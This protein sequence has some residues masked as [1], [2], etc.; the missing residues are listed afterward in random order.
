LRDQLRDWH[1]R[2]KSKSSQNVF[3][4]ESLNQN[5]IFEHKMNYSSLSMKAKKN[6]I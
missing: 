4:L 1:L 2:V 5:D 6:I 3:D